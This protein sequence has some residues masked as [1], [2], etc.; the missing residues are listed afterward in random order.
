MEEC[1]SVVTRVAMGRSGDDEWPGLQTWEVFGT[2]IRYQRAEGKCRASS[3]RRSLGQARAGDPLCDSVVV[4]ASTRLDGGWILEKE[5]M[6]WPAL[7][8]GHSSDDQM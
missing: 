7:E 5:M 3:D 2:P 8:G 6:H 4:G 1:N